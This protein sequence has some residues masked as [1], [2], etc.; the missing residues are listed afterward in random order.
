MRKIL[1]VAAALVA[2]AATGCRTGADVTIWG[3]CTPGADPTGTD[4]RYAMVCRDDRWTP[5]MTAE[6]FVDVS[7]GEPVVIA[8]L[9]KPPVTTTTAPTTTTT[10]APG[11]PTISWAVPP[12]GTIA[13]GTL[14]TIQG[15]N[16]TGATSVSIGGLPASFVVESDTSIA[17]TTPAHAAGFVDVVV[18]TPG[19]TATLAN[20]YRYL[21]TPTIDSVSPNLINAYSTGT[22]TISGT[23][24]YDVQVVQIGSEFVW[25]IDQ[26]STEELVLEFPELEAGDHDVTV[27]TPHGS[28]TLPMAINAR[29]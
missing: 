8:P 28:T 3:P 9:P 19:G 10:R 29:P 25:D 24:F 17:V 20:G 16:L 6:E 12:R 1:L 14:V 26:V 21:G 27:V 13:G 11:E 22:M 15:T 7:R 2:I 4:G 18:S 23:N 5:V